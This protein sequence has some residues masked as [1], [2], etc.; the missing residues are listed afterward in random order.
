MTVPGPKAE[1]ARVGPKTPAWVYRAMRVGARR[2]TYGFQRL[3]EP[4][5]WTED[6]RARTYAR[7]A[8]VH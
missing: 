2:S 1:A 6:R 3:E 4:C 7:S 8:V 5:R